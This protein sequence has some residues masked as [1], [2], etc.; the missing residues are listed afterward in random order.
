MQTLKKWIFLF[1]L[2]LEASLFAS[3]DLPGHI[4]FGD[5]STYIRI[6]GTLGDSISTSRFTHTD[7]DDKHTEN[8]LFVRL[9]V[10]G[11][12][13]KDF[14]FRASASIMSDKTSRSYKDPGYNPYNG[15]PFNV[16]SDD[17]RT[18]DYFT[19][20]SEYRLHKFAR[21]FGGV[22]YLE[23]GPA[24]RNKLSLKGE[25]TNYR[26]WMDSTDHISKPAPT[27]YFGYEFAIGPFTYTQYAGKLYHDKHKDK[28]FHAHRL[29]ISFP[30]QIRF[31]INETLIY[32]ST[33]ENAGT[34]ANADADSTNRSFEWIYAAPFVP[35]IFAQHYTG[36]L[37]NTGLGFDISIKTIPNWEIYG[38]ML[39]DDMKKVTSMFDDSWWGNKWA[40][41]IGVGTEN[42]KLGPITLSYF[43]EFTWIEPWV[44]THHKG[45]GYSYTHYGQSFGSEL[46]PN[47]REFYTEV[48]AAYQILELRFFASNV[49]KDTAFGGNLYDIHTP[50]DATDRTFLAKATTMHYREYGLGFRLSPFEWMA[51]NYTQSFFTGDAKG[52]RMSGNL[53]VSW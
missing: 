48:K 41:S 18:W 15:I 20:S 30:F 16:Q 6:R 24:R 3:Q 13:Q 35:Y 2:V 53:Q 52:Y 51:L 31:G 43:S 8:S 29:E 37:E 4:G 9:F 27:P 14:L 38:E 33:V 11:A 39:W 21:I 17:S 25:N 45:A 44:Y 5:S 47:S 50:Y 40:A 1:S 36:D 19:A 32:G 10:N 23:W 7:N 22:D 49:A 12:I 28:Y 26:P 42:R 46:G 34:N